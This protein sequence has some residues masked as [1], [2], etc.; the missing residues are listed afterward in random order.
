[1][2]K[3]VADRIR[4]AAFRIAAEQLTADEISGILDAFKGL[5]EDDLDAS[6][7]KPLSLSREGMDKLR[8]K[9]IH[10]SDDATAQALFVVDRDIPGILTKLANMIKLAKDPMVRAFAGHLDNKINL[11]S[12]KAN[13]KRRPEQFSA[14]KSFLLDVESAFFAVVKSA[15]RR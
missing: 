15:A 10:A 9:L 8:R 3:T 7:V 12:T 1:M 13:G 14:L 2:M 5:E 6:M 11:L 4:S